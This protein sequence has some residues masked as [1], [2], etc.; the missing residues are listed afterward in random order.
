MD[1]VWLL[2]KSHPAPPP[3]LINGACSRTLRP[4]DPPSLD[5]NHWE[6][7]S[8]TLKPL[9]STRT[10]IIWE[11]LDKQQEEFLL[12]RTSLI[13]DPS[14]DVRTTPE[15]APSIQTRTTPLIVGLPAGPQGL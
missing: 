11:N 4:S 7:P 14:P 8:R 10:P 5:P 9:T 15:L 12:G 1:V 6:K 13:S 2:L 3:R